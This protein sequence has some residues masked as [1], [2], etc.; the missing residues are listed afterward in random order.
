[1]LLF[2]GRQWTYAEFNA[3]VNKLAHLLAARGLERGDTVALFME[4]RA[5]FIMATLA[6]FK[7]GAAASL[8]NNSLSGAALIHC[9]EATATNASSGIAAAPRSSS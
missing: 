1:M 3:E 8:I 7:V 5:E 2:E 9:I 6:V 4:N